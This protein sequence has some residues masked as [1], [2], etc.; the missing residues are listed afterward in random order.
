MVGKHVPSLQ[1]LRALEAAVRLRSF[2]RAAEELALTQGAVSQQ[3]RLIEERLGQPL[4]RRS[5]AGVEPGRAALAL[6]IQ[7]RQGLGLLDRAF[8]GASARPVR[9]TVGRA[10]TQITVS[11][12]PSFAQRWLMPRVERFLARNPEID[13][14]LQSTFELARLDGSDGID[15]AIRY[16]PGG[17][18][19]CAAEKLMDE[20]TFPVAS[21]RYAGGR[22][23]ADPAALAGCALLRQTN[24]PWGPW[25]QAAGLDLAEPT[26]GP[27]FS[28]AGLAIAAAVAGQGVALARRALVAEDLAAGRLVRLGGCEVVD[29]HAYYLARPLGAGRAEKIAAFRDW[30]LEEVGQ[31]VP[32][33]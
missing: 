30:L 21:P 18:P 15:A 23:P 4:F 29:C 12:L 6:A 28:D 25:F 19:G 10:R 9:G 7:I 24:Q 32:V 14:E 5:A 31:G 17:W 8:E 13:L 33:A 11:V 3:I 26:S 20:T 22:L 16:G 1:A 2:T 27:K